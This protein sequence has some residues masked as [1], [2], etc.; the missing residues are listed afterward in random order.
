MDTTTVSLIVAGVGLVGV[1]LGAGLSTGANVLLAARKEAADTQNWRRDRALDAYSE[2]SR[3]VDTI[4]T[5]ANHAY[6]AELG[7]TTTSNTVRY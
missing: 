2:Y 1:A 6:V 4:M 3:L 7:A 5:E